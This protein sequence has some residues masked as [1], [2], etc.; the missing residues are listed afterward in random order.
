MKVNKDRRTTRWIAVVALSLAV[1]PNA[2]RADDASVR[3]ELAANY[4]K[5][6]MALDHKDSTSLRT[7]VTQD[8]TMEEAGKKMDGKASLA[9]IEKGFKTTGSVGED[10]MKIRTLKVNGNTAIATVAYKRTSTSVPDKKHKTHAIASNGITED[11]WV[12]T[13]SGWRLKSVKT[14]KSEMTVDGKPM[15]T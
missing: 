1:V 7:I 3:K 13:K 15:K 11:T 12:K 4:D 14:L 2:G 10:A 8:F 9:V 5:I 6:T